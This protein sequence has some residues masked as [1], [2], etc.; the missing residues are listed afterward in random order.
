MTQNSVNTS[1]IYQ[2][3]QDLIDDLERLLQERDREIL[4]LRE[5]IARLTWIL[6]EQD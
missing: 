6:Q 4:Q 3:Y 5:E 1:G 2:D